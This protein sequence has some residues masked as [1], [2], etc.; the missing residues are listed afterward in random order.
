MRT[1]EPNLKNPLNPWNP[2][3]L[4]PQ[5]FNRI[6]QRRPARRNVAGCKSDGEEEDRD[7]CEDGDVVRRNS[8]EHGAEGTGDDDRGGEAD[9]DAYECGHET[10]TQHQAENRRAIGAEGLADAEL[11]HALGDAEREDAVDADG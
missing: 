10:L 3:N 7:Q 2:E 9:D 4:L 6:Q 5:R 1:R 8:E 11:A